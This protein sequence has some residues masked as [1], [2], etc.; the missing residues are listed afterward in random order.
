MNEESFFISLS[1]D[2][3]ATLIAKMNPSFSYFL[4]FSY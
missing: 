4:S 1:M 3:K 2:F